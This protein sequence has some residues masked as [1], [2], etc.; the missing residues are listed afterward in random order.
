[1]ILWSVDRVRLRCLELRKD[2]G[3]IERGRRK[4]TSV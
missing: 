1:M 3:D 4:V 2:V